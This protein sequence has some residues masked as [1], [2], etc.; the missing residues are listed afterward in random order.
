MK[1]VAILDELKKSPPTLLTREI[2]RSLNKIKHICDSKYSN[3]SFYGTTSLNRRMLL[4]PQIAQLLTPEV[5]AYIF[6]N[7]PTAATKI[8]R[9]TSPGGLINLKD[10]IY[11]GFKDGLHF[12]HMMPNNEPD[13]SPQAYEKQKKKF[14][15][16]TMKIIANL[17]HA[18]GVDIKEIEPEKTLNPKDLVGQYKRIITI[19]NL[20]KREGQSD[21]L[22]FV[23]GYTAQE[24]R[25]QVIDGFQELCQK[26][27]TQKL[28]ETTLD[29]FCE[30]FLQNP[31]A[32]LDGWVMHLFYGRAHIEAALEQDTTYEIGSQ[33]YN[34][35]DIFRI[36]IQKIATNPDNYP[37]CA[38]EQFCLRFELV[39]N[40]L[41]NR[42]KETYEQVAAFQTKTQAIDQILDAFANKILSIG[43]Y[44]L[45][46]QSKARELLST[47][48]HYKNQ[49][50]QEPSQGSLNNFARQAKQAIDAAIPMLQKD[51]G[52]GDYLTNLA[53][54]LANAVTKA[55]IYT[56]TL[57]TINHPGFFTLKSSDAV[58][59]SRQLAQ[60]LNNLCLM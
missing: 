21:K 45:E 11:A 39:E 32:M 18:A 26:I 22:L 23:P 5:L 55:V 12:I 53:K 58:N 15:R 59:E 24:M 30:Q 36:M 28:T 27:N 46:A 29:N 56:V 48:Q 17:C 50:L 52:W 35:Q 44:H 8:K 25:E 13:Y 57:G 7:E 2:E 10:A 47:L 20:L 49:A 40:D 37:A 31:E 38:K 42:F 54:Q 19:I 14:L 51:L 4:D 34:F 6:T 33:H 41:K 3:Q 60:E 9:N 16:N 1:I 43:A